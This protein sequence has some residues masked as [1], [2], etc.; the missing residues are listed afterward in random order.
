MIKTEALTVVD[1]LKISLAWIPIVIIL[2]HALGYMIKGVKND[3][4]KR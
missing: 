4:T 3:K 2:G 1:H